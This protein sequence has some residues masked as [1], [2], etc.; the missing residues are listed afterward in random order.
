MRTWWKRIRIARIGRSS[1][2]NELT[3]DLAGSQINHLRT[4]DAAVDQAL[5]VGSIQA[6]VEQHQSSNVKTIHT[7]ESFIEYAQVDGAPEEA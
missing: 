3:E 4:G 2:E 1:T 5:R 7:Q 6:R